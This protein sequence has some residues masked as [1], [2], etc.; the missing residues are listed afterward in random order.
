MGN[1]SLCK[2]IQSYLAALGLTRGDVAKHIGAAFFRNPVPEVFVV[3]PAGHPVEYHPGDVNIR[4]IV[5]E[6]QHKRPGRPGKGAAVNHQ[7]NR[8]AQPLCN[9]GG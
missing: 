4:V 1:D 7:H 2:G 6:P 5:L 8:K 3:A 9:L